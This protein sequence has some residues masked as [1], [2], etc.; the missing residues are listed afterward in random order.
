MN[1]LLLVFSTL[2]ISSFTYYLLVARNKNRP[3]GPPLPPGPK[4]LPVLG[5]LLQLG[6]KP[7][8]TLQALAKVYGP[9]FRLKLGSVDIVVAGSA[10][11]A[12]QFLKVHDDNFSDRPRSISAEHLAFNH[13]DLVFSNY[14]PRW[15]MYRR[16]CTSQL[17]SQKAIDNF[18]SVR[19]SEVDLLARALTSRAENNGTM[20]LGKALNVCTANTL[21]MSMFS[22]RVFVPE[23]ESGDAAEF[24]EMVMDLFKFAGEFYLRDYVPALRWFDLDGTVGRMKRLHQRFNKFY[25]KLIDEHAAAAKEGDLLSVLMKLKEDDDFEGGKLTNKDIKALLFDLYAAGTDTSSIA[26]EWAMSEMIRNP[27]ILKE[28][29][30]EIDSVVGRDRLLSEA[31]LPNLPL[32]HAI[33]K[34]SL[35][36]HPSVPLSVPHLSK[37]ACEIN[38]YRIPKDTMLLPN[39][40][41]IA[42]D[43]E[44]WPDPLEYRPARFLPGGEA[45]HVD[46]KGNDFQILPFSAGRRICV[47]MT[48]GLKMVQLITG[49]LIHGFDWALPD[50]RRGEM[51]DMEEASGLT[52]ERAVPL[53]VHPIPRLATA[54]YM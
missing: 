12:T 36:L 10:A 53:V 8:H 25:D 31:D 15:R 4:G 27:D 50:G 52:L 2:F 7:H 1:P 42:R 30:K 39:L 34:E 11:V 29:Q 40:W 38:G 49:T 19:E 18:R 6:D 46:V 9:L 43:P 17:F 32:L 44:L 22:R 23:E 3:K 37:E 48:M 45:E 13:E 14:G 24:K 35:R 51:L 26:I 33:I 54:A 16:L 41:A 5:N 21:S 20:D 28:A 47:G